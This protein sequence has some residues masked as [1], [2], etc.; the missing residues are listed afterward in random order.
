[1]E[2]YPYCQTLWL[3]YLKNL[4]LLRDGS[5]SSELRKAALYVNDRCAVFYLIEG[6]KYR[7]WLENCRSKSSV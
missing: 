5:F 2:Q 3:L 7:L 4:Y 6:D 1:L